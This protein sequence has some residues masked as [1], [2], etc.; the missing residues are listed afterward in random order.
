M[1]R[2][3]G[4]QTRGIVRMG[5]VGNVRPQA[6]A[7]ARQMLREV[8]ALTWRDDGIVHAVD[9]KRRRGRSKR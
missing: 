7:C 2:N 5:G 8:L 3:F 6:E 4:P 1:C 9:D